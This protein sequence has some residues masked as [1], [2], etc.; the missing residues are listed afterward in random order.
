MKTLYLILLPCCF[1]L[2]CRKEKLK[3]DIELTNQSLKTV[4]QYTIG[5]WKLL[6]AGG[7]FFGNTHTV[8]DE[9][10]IT[11]SKD[12]LLWMAH[13]TIM[14]DTTLIWKLTT[15]NDGSKGY[16][17]SSFY[18]DGFPLG[19]VPLRV[20]NGQMKWSDNAS[21]GFGYTLERVH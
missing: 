3:D 21:D 4:Q 16:F 5:K 20:T 19:F 6:S 10:Y 1:S 14:A 7:G 13:D 15:V 9:N 17:M 11:I 8:Y 2:A 12:H 18:L